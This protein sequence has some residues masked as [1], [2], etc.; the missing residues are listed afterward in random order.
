MPNYQNGK[1][2]KIIN[3]ENDDIYIGSTCETLSQRIAKHRA[4]LKRYINGERHYIT[5]FKILEKTSATII[6]LENYPCNSKEEL[7]AREAFYIKENDC[8][9]KIIPLRTDKQYREDNKDVLSEKAKDRY[10]NNEDYREYIKL[11]SKQTREAINSD[12]IKTEELKQYKAEWYLE[13]KETISGKAKTYYEATKETAK[14]RAKA[15]YEANK[16]EIN[17]KKR[18]ARLKLKDT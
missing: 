5:S 3:Y 17:R 6:L 1:I 16:D 13:N 15:R 7:T 8:V 10:K 4:D 2:Y 14:A 9:N 12:P 11:N 18:E